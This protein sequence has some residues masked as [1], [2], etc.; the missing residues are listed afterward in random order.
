MT[1]SGDLL[2]T[3]QV[4]LVSCNSLAPRT[5]ELNLLRILEAGGP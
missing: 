5:L 3:V 4:S 2:M 1:E